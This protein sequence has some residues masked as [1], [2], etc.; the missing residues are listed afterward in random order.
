MDSKPYPMK[1]IAKQFLPGG[2]RLLS[3]GVPIMTAPL[4]AAQQAETVEDV[5]E[6]QAFEV[7]TESETGYVASNVLS[8]YR[9][10]ATIKEI[11]F[12]I[13]VVT[14]EFLADQAAVNLDDAVQYA[15]GVSI[16]GTSLQELDVYNIRGLSASRPKR[17]GYRR[18]YLSD[19]TNVQRVEV[20]KGPASALFGEAQPGGIINYITK[21]PKAE[22]ETEISLR[23][24]SWDERRIGIGKTGPLLDGRKDLLYRIDTSYQRSNGYRDYAE[25]E[26]AVVAPVLQWEI[27][28]RTKVILDVEWIYKRFNPPSANLLW[29]ESAT[30]AYWERWV[31]E[32]PQDWAD[33]PE[34]TAAFLEVLANDPGKAVQFKFITQPSD[35]PTQDGSNRWTDIYPESLAPYTYATNGPDAFVRYDAMTYTGEI[36]HKVSDWLSVRAV[37]SHGETDTE[38]WR[39]NTKR[40]R[41]WGDGLQQGKRQDS[42]LNTVFNVQADA[43]INFEIGPTK[44]RL[45]VGAEYFGDDFENLTIR[46][47]NAAGANESQLLVLF[48]PSLE[49]FALY[50]RNFPGETNPEELMSRVTRISRDDFYDENGAP[51]LIESDTALERELESVYIS[52]QVSL[53]DD[54]VKILA[55]LRHDRVNQTF[56]RSLTLTEDLPFETPEVDSTTPQIGINWYATGSIVL[57]GNYSESFTPVEGVL[58]NI[59]G[60]ESEKPPERGEGTEFGI[61]GS[62]LDGRIS[63]TVAWFDISKTDVVRP[64]ITNDGERY[65]IL[66]EGQSSTGYEADIVAY[67]TPNWQLILGYA[68]IEAEESI[69]EGGLD[70]DKRIVGVPEDQVTL[71]TKYS[72]KDSFLE[73]LE[74][75]GGMTYMGERRGG[76]TN[77]D[78]LILDSYTKVDAFLAYKF[79]RNNVDYKL[80]LKIDNVFDELYFRPGPYVGD[81]TNATLTLTMKF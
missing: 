41:V 70:F 23:Y 45:V 40:V 4:L 13:Q 69:E 27:T 1:F 77:Q 34:A 49:L 66:V 50:D 15:A 46:S 29:N 74:I 81:P 16:G 6:L 73:G 11:P 78:F 25:E 61:K 12:N 31:G 63:A 52:D 62:F 35:N 14:A 64:G 80:S 72:F 20:V 67:P 2:F 60:T 21:R 33:L 58:R 54:T 68:H 43:L 19:M 65:D 36:Q 8:A 57:Y 37:I 10:N 30:R 42:R 53:F 55:G 39:A 79:N 9:V 3:I 26:R 56:L 44:H 28:P 7:T 18:Y 17:N 5:F 38:I 32:A 24:G 71:W 47:N 48:E 51:R 22:P 76:Q 75:G 59:D